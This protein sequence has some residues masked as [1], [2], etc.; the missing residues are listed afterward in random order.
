MPTTL[1]TGSSSGIGYATALHLAR[2]GH[3]VFASMRETSRG[4]LLEQAASKEG[5]AITLLR[6]DVN[7]DASVEAAVA[8]VL[9][10]SDQVDVLIN[11]AGIGRSGPVEE[12]PIQLYRDAMETNFFGALRCIHAVLPHMRRQRSG[13]IV[14]V[15]SIAGRIALP[16]HSAYNA[17][18]WALEA[19]SESLAQEIHEF[20]IRVVIIEPGHIWT[21]MWEKRRPQP[22]KTAYPN[23]RGRMLAIMDGGMPYSSPAEIVSVR[24]AEAIN[25]DRPRLRY[26]VGADAEALW[27]VRVG[28]SDEEWLAFGGGDEPAAW[29]KMAEKAFEN[30][31]R[32]TDA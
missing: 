15:S 27:S 17:S 5:L 10:R 22:E 32:R 31:P 23:A 18:K 2:N 13:C 6:L 26:L 20:G 11:N 25:T 29:E 30:N 12:T 9:E 14:N 3:N 28:M 7:D 8:T 1:I 21:A 16:S 4:E 24:I 19:M